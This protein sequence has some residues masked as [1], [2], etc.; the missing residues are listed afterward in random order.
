MSKADV[1]KAIYARLLPE[2]TV[3]GVTD[4]KSLRPLV[5]A[6]F[7]SEAG[8]TEAGAA[9]Y[10]ANN[11][12]RGGATGAYIQRGNGHAGSGYSYADNQTNKDDDRPL[13]SSV[14][15]N[16][17][18]KVAAVAAFMNP[19]DALARAKI[20]R[21]IC[22]KGAPEI[23]EDV[24]PSAVFDETILDADGAEQFALT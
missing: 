8:C 1:C 18:K 22:V 5:I 6:A 21:G 10:Y 2:Y 12:S 20:V 14:Q 13:Y 23:G 24:D 19:A 15:L 7:I 9:T 4:F 3:D 17:E 11:K 16:R